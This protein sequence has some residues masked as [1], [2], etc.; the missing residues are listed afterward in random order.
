MTLAIVEPLVASIGKSLPFV[1]E[2][3]ALVRD[4]LPFIRELLALVRDA[5]PFIRSTLQIVKLAPQPLNAFSV[6]RYGFRLSPVFSHRSA[7]ERAPSAAPRACL[8]D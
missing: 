8:P 6:R 7:C 4:A 2:L 3:L 5:L 1:R